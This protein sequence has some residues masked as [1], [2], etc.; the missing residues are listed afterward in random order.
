MNRR[1][2]FPRAHRLND[3]ARIRELSETGASLTR[4]PL[5]LLALPN[6]L[7]HPRMGIR[8]GRHVGIAA[9]RNRIKRLLREAFRLMQHDWPRGYDLLVI[10]RPHA[11][12][13]LAEYQRILSSSMVK[14]H[15]SAG[16]AQG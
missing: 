14:L 10:V 4:G 13:I 15:G 16:G 7:A 9:R 2:T 11:P 6:D 5:K 3:G 1:N 12:L 8:I